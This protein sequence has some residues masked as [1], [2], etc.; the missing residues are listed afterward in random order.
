[1]R[2]LERSLQRTD[3]GETITEALRLRKAIV[4]AALL[5]KRQQ[6]DADRHSQQPTAQ[7]AE[8]EDPLAAVLRGMNRAAEDDIRN[9]RLLGS[10]YIEAERRKLN[11]SLPTNDLI[12]AANQARREFD[13][14]CSN[15]QP[16]LGRR[17]LADYEAKLE[18]MIRLHKQSLGIYGRWV[19]HSWRPWTQVEHEEEVQVSGEEE[20][21]E[22]EAGPSIPTHSRH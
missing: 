9:I 1:M 11:S 3:H 5:A 6:Q 13:A 21:G 19:G 22:E 20:A 14:A 2:R 17:L 18:Q 15:V 10:S 16:E 7:E 12:L 8:D 4:S